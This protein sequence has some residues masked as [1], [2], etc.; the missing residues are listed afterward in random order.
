M[1]WLKVV[2]AAVLSGSLFALV[3][4]VLPPRPPQPFT[5]QVSDWPGDQIFTLIDL[6]GVGDQQIHFDIRRTPPSRDPVPAFRDGLVDAVLVGLDR[7]PDLAPEPVR[8]IYAVDEVASGGGL[9]GGP[10]ISSAMVLRNRHVGVTFGTAAQPV[11]LALLARIGLGPREVTLESL[12]PE[13]ASAALESGRLAA[14][15]TLAPGQIAALKAL[16]GTTLLASTETQ[17]GLATHVLVVRE[18]AITQQR[19]RLEAVIGT[20]SDVVGHCRSDMS[21]CL[22]LIAGASGRPAEDWRQDFE[23]VHLLD[24]ADNRALLTGGAGAPIAA[25]IAA[26]RTIMS[27]E[28]QPQPGPAASPADLVDPSLVETVVRP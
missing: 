15:A 11:V 1:I 26:T 23:A 8:I 10:G 25:R 13:A 14:V 17:T 7:L 4:T 3:E 19:P 27:G 18:S 6:M 24:G 20:L 9:I 5:I 28:V 2:T 16:R 21:R 22:D 12:A